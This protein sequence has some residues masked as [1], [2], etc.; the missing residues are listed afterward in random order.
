M[1]E[2]FEIN[3]TPI[4]LSEVKEC[5]VVQ[6]EMVMRPVFREIDSS[7]TKFFTGKNYRF[8]AMDPYGVI[9]GGTANEASTPQFRPLEMVDSVVKD[10]MRPFNAAVDTLGDVLNVKTIK[11][12]KYRI[13]L[14]SDRIE[15]VYL[16]DIPAQVITKD[17]RII[18]VYRS[19]PEYK[20]L[21]E[22]TTSAVELVQAVQI[23]F[24][25]KKKDM[26]FYGVGFHPI[27]V[28]DMYAKLNMAITAYREEIQQ[29]KADTPKGLLGIPNLKLPKIGLPSISIQIGKP[30]QN[31]TETTRLLQ[32]S[33]DEEQ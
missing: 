17:N 24:N 9:V 25:N 27:N 13:R 22:K 7:M 15:D 2:Y 6:R 29:Q 8:E 16:L 23:L 1:I 31:V 26:L 32:D 28:I 5:R 12:K 18:D 14:L 19:S 4:K 11:H 10:V 21:G 20:E 33:E 30:K 3:S